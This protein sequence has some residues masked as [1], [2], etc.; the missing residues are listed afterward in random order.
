MSGKHDDAL[1]SDMIANEIRSQQSFEA[2]FKPEIIHE[3]FHD[4]TLGSNCGYSE[5]PYD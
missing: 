4:D 5:S 3:S 2:E 1:F